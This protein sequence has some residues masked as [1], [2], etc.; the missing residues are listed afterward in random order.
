MTSVNVL[1]RL[2]SPD[3]PYRGIQPFRLL[4]WRIFFERDDETERLGNLIS[5][6]RAVLLYGQ[7]GCGK[8]S[9]LNA[10]LL[11]HALRRGRIPERIRV[12][13]ERG[14]ELVVD[15]IRLRDDN[16]DVNDPGELPLYLQS[17]FISNDSLARVE[18]S[19]DQFLERLRAP[20]EDLGE[21][22]L[23]FDQFEE[24]VTL[25]EENP[26][27]K[28][29]LESAQDARAG[30][31]KML[32]ELLLKDPL[33]MRIV[34]AFRDDY[35]A[36]LTPLF[37]RIPN[38]TDQ[39]MLLLAPRVEFTKRIV[40]GPFV[41]SDDNER[42]LPGHFKG[43]LSPELADKIT[44]GIGARSPAGILSLSELQMI[45]QV[46]W[47]QPRLQ[48]T[49][50]RSTAPAKVVK[51]IIKSAAL[52]AMKHLAPWDRVGAVAF[53]SNLVTQDGTR[54]IVSAEKLIGAARRTLL[55]I[56]PRTH[57]KKLLDRLPNETGLIRR[58]L[59]AGTTYYEIT[60]EFL[61]PWIQ[62]TKLTYRHWRFMIL[63]AVCA[64]LCIAFA[65]WQ[66][67]EAKEKARI[68][69]EG[70][71]QA[72]EVLEILQYNVRDT[73][74]DANVVTLEMQASVSKAISDYWRE[75]PPK[76]HDLHAHR[77]AASAH[78]TYSL[79]LSEQGHTS[80]A[81]AE[82]KAATDTYDKL[83]K[84]EPDSIDY[85]RN[86]SIVYSVYADLLVRNP[87]SVAAL[88]LYNTSLA[89]REKLAAKK[90]DDTSFMSLRA[91]A[92]S[93]VG[94][95]LRYQG[96]LPGALRRFNDCL[97]IY[98]KLANLDRKNSNWQE[99]LAYCDKSIADVRLFQGDLKGALQL[100]RDCC[101]SF[102]R[103]S[104]LEPGNFSLR[105]N[106]AY[107]NMYLA[108]GLMLQG[109]L[110]GA[111]DLDNK[112]RTTVENLVKFDPANALWQDSRMWLNRHLGLVQYTQGDLT[113]ASKRYA[114]SLE[115]AEKLAQQEP[116][117]MEF[118][119]GRY[120]VYFSL[121]D[122]LRAK[123]DLAGALQ[124]FRD[125][126]TL[127]NELVRS[128]PKFAVL[129]ND[130]CDFQ[131]R[132]GEVLRD[133]HDLVGALKSCRDS[134]ELRQKLA[135]QDPTNAVWMSNVADAYSDVGDVLWDQHDL[136]GALQDYRESY[137]IRDNLAKMDPS[138]VQWRL[139]LADN[140]DNIAKVLVAQ[141]NVAEARSLL[142]SSRATADELGTLAPTYY[143]VQITR[144]DVRASLA[145]CEDQTTLM[146]R[147]HA[148]EFLRDALMILQALKER[149]GLQPVHV[150][151]MQD[152]LVKIGR[153]EKQQ[154]EDIAKSI[155]TSK[156]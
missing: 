101:A 1:D 135:K 9:L 16:P 80:K 41:K 117:D 71:Q 100:Y 156:T 106:L 31:E 131:G 95:A 121:G 81:L 154:S 19:C 91:S 134:L 102:E 116:G 93:A 74:P 153:L 10:G 54:D 13:P 72:L 111:A 96:D 12:F 34:F 103:V 149:T 3:E 33:P 104:K 43:E 14:R 98:T 83:L 56:I 140:E 112:S 125:G 22:L 119:N 113:G 133:Q 55:H 114:D 61:I 2:P 18:L 29:R 141:G 85:A 44:E 132:I 130:L 77:E 8:S 148:H 36:R 17:R 118:Q 105:F 107:L 150:A 142:D 137:A 30:I 152:Y 86:A 4:D 155:K 79:L 58:N 144:A 82:S 53:L 122:L 28:A 88:K 21:P 6:Y 115:I 67:Q 5:M 26:R 38:L 127:A 124:R 65:Y 92:Y 48:E 37:A 94:W 147:E 73:F 97:A 138:N 63:T 110:P 50:L 90:P 99:S 126:F 39:R 70:E 66:V 78:N 60:S 27:D 68:A 87:D 46:L 52:S 89:L 120:S 23:I 143:L 32:C 136:I 69:Q 11:P 35:L 45:C 84:E 57:L 15:R 25:F 129:E 24:F 40:R 145:D 59:G 64:I 75:H 123:G 62:R 51:E 128:D 139:A 42:G 108:N 49:L 146:S 151:R 109:D 47:R 20:S 76:P 7:S